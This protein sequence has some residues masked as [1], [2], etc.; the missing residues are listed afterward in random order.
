MESNTEST[1]QMLGCGFLPLP[2][3]SLARFRRPPTPEG[4]KLPTRTLPDGRLTNEPTVCPG[5]LTSLP[6]VIEVARA[7]FHWERG[8]LASIGVTDWA[9]DPLAIGIEIL[10]GASGAYHNWRTTP[11][12][13]GGGAD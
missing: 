1:R 8:G 5:Y 13:N 6:E 9:G 4:S 7:R 2:A 11:K 10:E 3:E 12:A